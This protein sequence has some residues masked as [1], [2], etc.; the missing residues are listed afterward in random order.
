MPLTPT[1][2]INEL[3]GTYAVARLF[4]I[5]PPSVHEWHTAG[6]PENRLIRL[7]VIAEQRG[8]AHRIDFFPNNHWE[9][10]PDLPAPSAAPKPSVTR[11]GAVAQESA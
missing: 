10:W 1:E 6:I 5:K 2:L 4:G 7:A 8:I 3:G 11:K 9:I